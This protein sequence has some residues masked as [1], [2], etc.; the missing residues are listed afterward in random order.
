MP[1]STIRKADGS[2]VY[3]WRYQQGGHPAH[4]WLASDYFD[5]II[6]VSSGEATSNALLA[7]LGGAR[8]GKNK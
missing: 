8:K 2:F 4:G 1:P 6:A 3:D 5:A 7:Q